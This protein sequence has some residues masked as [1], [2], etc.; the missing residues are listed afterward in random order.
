[1]GPSRLIYGVAAQDRARRSL[2]QVTRWWRWDQ[3]VAADTAPLG[4]SDGQGAR[5]GGLA[6]RAENSR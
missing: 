3:L 2:T 5:W 6:A 4:Q 1:M